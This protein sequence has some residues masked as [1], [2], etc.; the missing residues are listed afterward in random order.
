MLQDKT[1]QRLVPLKSDIYQ[2]HLIVKRR[3]QK[4]VELF[5]LRNEI[6]ISGNG[7]QEVPNPIQSFEEV[8]F[9]G[10]ISRALNRQG[11]ENPTPIQAQGWPLAL[12]GRNVVGIAGAG[13][14]KK[15]AYILPAIQHVSAQLPLERG[16]GPIAVV[17]VATR[18]TAQEIQK[19]IFAYSNPCRL[20]SMCLFG[21]S[22]RNIANDLTTTGYE[23]VVATPWRLLD[24]LCE[25]RVNLN[26]C[27]YLVLDETDVML[28]MGFEPQLNRVFERTRPDL[29][30][31]M[32]SS[33]WSP[34]LERLATKNMPRFTQINVGAISPHPGNH[35]VIQVV[36]IVKEEEKL[37]KLKELLTEIYD[38][39]DHP[40][41]ILVFAERKSC[42]STINAF[43]GSFVPCESIHGDKTQAEREEVLR[44]FRKGTY[45][46]L[47]ATDIASLNIPAVKFV[48]NYDFPC[49][50]ESYLQRIERTGL[51]HTPHSKSFTF[52]TNLN[53]KQFRPMLKML[54]DAKQPISPDLQ[55]LSTE[56]DCGNKKRRPFRKWKYRS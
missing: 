37:N 55:R 21:G 10:L 18:E 30:I 39:S 7:R 54:K 32:W 13:S 45:N 12:S 50:I 44:D 17:L 47:V 27:T 33:T 46:I 16:D 26:R 43:I 51:S 22:Y 49:S 40:G 2:E 23:V 1:G 48:I 52:L 35:D 19:E 36:E 29:Q 24:F 15:L 14:G 4:E 28:T 6:T 11:Y 25:R 5:R 31:L 56:E 20:R 9:D 53:E 42:V 41:K 3:S 38:I 8:S 34:I